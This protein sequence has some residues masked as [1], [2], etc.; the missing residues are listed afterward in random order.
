MNISGQGENKIFQDNTKFSQASLLSDDEIESF[1]AVV[2]T[3]SF[4]AAAKKLHKSQSS[5]SYSIK[6]LEQKLSVQIFD[7][8]SKQIT[9]TDAGKTIHNKLLNILKINNEIFE[10]TSLI[11][12]GIETKIRLALTAVTPTP[13]VVEALRKFN[14][15]FPQT[16]IELQFTT[17]DEPIE[18]L[19]NDEVDFA[20]SA[21][22]MNHHDFDR[23]QWHTVEFMAVAAANHPAIMPEIQ[24]QD[25]LEMTNLVVGGR[26]TLMKKEP[27]SQVNNSNIWHV[28]DF[29][30]KK[31]LLMNGLGWGYMPRKII[32]RELEEGILQPVRAK[33]LIH[34]Q[35]DLIRKK[36]KYKGPG[37]TYLWKCLT[38][39]M[40]EFQNTKP[41]SYNYTSVLS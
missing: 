23:T 9:L 4:S 35:L 8:S 36:S 22:K 24:E 11:Q 30:F 32:E 15:K 6:K 14:Q 33:A 16:Q 29:L 18:Y 10:F 12:T 34:K 5:I 13:L 41:S 20:I 31:E 7:R 28:T 17:H 21:S 2:D 40:E 25:L 39:A 26:Q 27:M 1:L 19:V 37:K 3:G 38:E